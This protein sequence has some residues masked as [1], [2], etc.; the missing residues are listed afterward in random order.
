V[1]TPQEELTKESVSTAYRNSPEEEKGEMV[2]VF[3]RERVPEASNR[4]RRLFPL[5]GQHCCWFDSSTETFEKEYEPLGY[6]SLTV[7]L[8]DCDQCP[9]KP[10][11]MVGVVKTAA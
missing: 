8:F 10:E 3:S 9:R 2:G 11:G 4:E 5:P 1:C 7:M 6:G